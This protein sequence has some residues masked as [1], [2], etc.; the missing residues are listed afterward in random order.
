MISKNLCLW[1]LDST[2]CANNRMN[3]SSIL[4]MNSLIM[5]SDDTN[6]N[7]KQHQQ[8]QA[9]VPSSHAHS[10]SPSPSPSSPSSVALNLSSNSSTAHQRHSMSSSATICET[11]HR[12]VLKSIE[13]IPKETVVSTLFGSAFFD[14]DDEIDDDDFQVL[15]TQI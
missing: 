14:A 3:Q 10:S 1:L 15:T 6:T 12:K 7:Q 8:Q 11:S 9:V 13:F 2:D 5:S 4:E